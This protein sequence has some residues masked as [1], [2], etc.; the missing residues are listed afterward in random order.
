VNPYDELSVS[1]D[2]SSDDIRKAYKSKAQAC[3]PDHG[4][5]VEEFKRLSVSYNILRDPIKRQD[6]DRTGSTERIVTSV[7]SRLAELFNA[8]LSTPNIDASPN[9]VVE[10]QRLLGR[11]IK[12]TEQSRA[13]VQ[14]EVI[15][16]N[17]LKARVTTDGDNLFARM[18]QDQIDSK[19]RAIEGYQKELELLDEVKT[20]LTTYKDEGLTEWTTMNRWGEV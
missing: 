11:G 14:S 3:H 17:K 9:I 6:Y 4:G 13:K 2:A 7:V 19:Q 12:A 1:V 15:K 20:L 5:D 18:V 8:V 10:S 16:L